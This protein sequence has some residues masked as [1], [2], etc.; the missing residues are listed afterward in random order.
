M[1][2]LKNVLLA[3]Y[4]S[5]GCGGVAETLVVVKDAGE[6]TE[7]LEQFS[8]QKITV[9]GF[10]TN[11]LV[12]DNGV[13]GTTLLTQG[14]EIVEHGEVVVADAG[15]WWDDLVTYVLQRKQWGIEL[16]SGIPSS[17]GG[18]VMGNIAAYG[19][20]VSDTLCWI[21]VYNVSRHE[22]SKINVTDIDFSY[23]RSSL[24]QQ[25]ELIILR[26]AFKLSRELTTPLAYASAASIAEEMKL[27]PG[28]LS[29][30]RN[31]IMEA[32]KR[33]GSLY[34]PADKNPEHTAG[35]FFKNPDIDQ[36]QVQAIAEHDETGKS[37]QLLL[38]QNKIHGGSTSRVSAAH[39]LLAAGFHRGQA[40]GGVRLHPDHI[41]KI[42]N[43]NGAS[44][45]EV[46]DVAQ[47]I[48]TEVKTKLGIVLEPEVKFIGEFKKGAN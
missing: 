2:V 11:S 12:S 26:A 29:Q 6:L 36:S 3:P 46:Y 32:R 18:A 43:F 7:A 33:A 16:M 48:I 45:Q 17:V 34:D 23:R 27:D 13:A 35:S 10:G 9:L 28:D 20:Q 15:V 30:R 22:I 39:V 38:D 25:P 47:L 21:E 14:G 4:T 24:Q 42:E 5:L 44:A 8:N 19:Q 41:L 31:I 1:Q 40:W 37:L